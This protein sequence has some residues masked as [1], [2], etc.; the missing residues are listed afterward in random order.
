[1]RLTMRKVKESFEW[2]AECKKFVALAKIFL[3][4]AV[5][6]EVTDSCIRFASPASAWS[7]L[8]K[9][10]G[11]R[12]FNLVLKQ[13]QAADRGNLVG[14]AD[15]SRGSVCDVMVYCLDNAEAGV[16]AMARRLLSAA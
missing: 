1:M 13:G 3:H 9:A 8:K 5:H 14:K 6:I 2:R 10:D 11:C 16:E 7:Q 4:A 12:F 15:G